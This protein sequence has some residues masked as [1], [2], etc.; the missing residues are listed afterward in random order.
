MTKLKQLKT[1]KIKNFKQ[2]KPLTKSRYKLALDCP[3]KLFYTGKKEYENQ[4]NNDT[5][6]EALAEGGYQVGELA[7]CYYP[8]GHDITDRGYDAPLAKTNQLLEQENVVI[9]E[10][11]V[12]YKNFFI[13]VDVL[14]KK[15]NTINLIEVKAKSYDGGDADGFLSKKGFVSS[16]W[17]PY[18]E[19]VAFQKYVMQKAFPDKKI[20]AY[21][22]LADKS[23]IASVNGLNQLFQIVKGKDDRKSVK[24][25][26]DISPKALG[27]PVLSKVNVDEIADLIMRDEAY[28]DKPEMAFEEKI[29]FWADHY[30]NDQKIISQV[31]LRCFNCEFNTDNPDKKSGFREC[32]S[33]FYTW[34]E[35]QYQ[36]P[37]ITE[38]WN[39]RGKKKLF[40]EQGILF[41]DEVLESH[42]GDT[43]PDK[44]GTI[45]SAERKWLQVEKVQQNDHS[46]YLDKD[47]M[48]D[49]MD[50]FSYPLHFID[51]ETSMVAIPFYKGQHPYE[52]VAF[53]FSHHIMNDDGT[54]EHIGEFIETEKGKFPNF[55]FLRALKKGLENDKGTIFRYAAHE[56]SVLNQIEVQLLRADKSIVPDKEELITFIHSITH[57]D[58]IRKGERDMVD[59][60]KMVKDY[61]YDPA[62]RGSNSIKVVLPAALNASDYIQK[63]YSKPIYGRNSVIKSLNFET[64]WRWIQKDENGAIKS[65]YKL[66]PALF[67]DI[68]PE[69]AE[70]FIADENLADGGAAM[71]AF[72]KMQFTDIS[73]TER[74][75]IKNGLLKYCELDT[76]AMVMIYEFWMD[77]VGK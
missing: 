4:Q 22:M 18:L 73:E 63:K 76:L 67:D 62:M 8:G 19:D 54:I 12:Q 34:T 38:I 10:A 11:A 58:K 41:M 71:V 64:G 61:Y 75:A 14:E 33:R 77:E 40:K 21:L 53:Q 23:K 39:F 37:K 26:S 24:I 3:T 51:F 36:K 28:K 68:D 72:A 46:F 9:F 42:L 56:N 55:N 32:W 15:G 27:T 49:L 45:S 20:K 47:G 57:R 65:P 30:K 60:L 50:S 1:S 52:Q 70:N 7:K 31:D 29:N 69:E 13:R 74:E 17:S 6:L 48:K 16:G 44:N 25:V 5:F 66:L 35:E 43:T 2:M 59:M